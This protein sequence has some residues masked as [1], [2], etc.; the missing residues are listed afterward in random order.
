MA[1]GNRN[2]VD[3]IYVTDGESSDNGRII[4]IGANVGKTLEVI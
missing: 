2:F 3:Q 4:D 1:E